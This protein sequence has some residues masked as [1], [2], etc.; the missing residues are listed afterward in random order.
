[1]SSYSPR[2]TSDAMSVWKK[3]RGLPECPLIFS[4]ELQ[5]LNGP[6]HMGNDIFINS[7]HL[8]SCSPNRVFSEMM[9]KIVL[10][11]SFL[12]ES[13]SFA[14]RLENVLKSFRGTLPS[15]CSVF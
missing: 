9:S 1:M 4:G 5:S 14:L 12:D 13:F 11:S 2:S 7:K 6:D 3:S 8:L 15:G 10:F